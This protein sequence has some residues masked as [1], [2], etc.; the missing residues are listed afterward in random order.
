MGL[1]LIKR[2]RAPEV[3][4]STLDFCWTRKFEIVETVLQV[5]KGGIKNRGRGS[6]RPTQLDERLVA[7]RYSVGRPDGDGPRISVSYTTC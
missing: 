5:S 4:G 1:V 3:L 6:N 2:D 7:A